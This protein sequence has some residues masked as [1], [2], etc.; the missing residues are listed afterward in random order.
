MTVTSTKR[1]DGWRVVSAVFLLF[2]TSAGLGFYGL[3]VYLDAITD[4][5]GFSTSSVSLATSMF[6]LVSAVVGRMIARPVET[7][8]IR[9]L[10]TV[11]AVLSAAALALLGRVTEVWQLYAVYLL[12]AVGFALSGM[13]PGTTL[14]TRWFHERRS[15]ALAV[16][17]TGLSVGGLTLTQLASWLI[18]REGLS[19]ATPWLGG[20]YLVLAL[21]ATPFMW[22]DPDRR[23]QLPD[24]RPPAEADAEGRPSR[25]M[26]IPYDPA[27]RSHFFRAATAGYLLIM[28]AQVGGIAHIANLG[29]DRV[30]RATGALAVLALALASVLFRLLG[31]VVAT[32]VPLVGYT[33]SLAVL[34]GASLVALAYADS[35]VAIV[36]A[37]FVMG[38]TV[39]NLLMLQ[40][41]LVAEAF[42]VLAYARLFSLNQLLVTIGVGLGPFV[43]GV[44][45]DVVS[46]RLGFAVAAACSVA[47]AAVLSSAGS[48]AATRTM[49]APPTPD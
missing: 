44:L 13:I 26:G 5:Q 24:G 8:R 3:A 42:G 2:V 20:I 12:F 43:V 29:T 28:T 10:V 46:Y 22:P 4:E 23:G 17:S 47:G 16:A 38:A 9:E 45:E 31:G 25:A 14:V 34:Q 27:V 35:R 11:G 18:D 41:L 48:I 36:G 6:F 7:G 1:F 37:A 15:V 33:V 49:L 32:R 40:A 19:G 39:G 30:D 21:A